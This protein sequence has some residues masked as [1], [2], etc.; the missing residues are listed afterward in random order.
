MT[1]IRIVLAALVLSAASCVAAWAEDAPVPPTRPLEGAPGAGTPRTAGDQPAQP[2]A[3][4]APIQGAAR[5]I[6]PEALAAP[7]PAIPPPPLLCC[8]IHLTPDQLDQI[9]AAMGK[10]PYADVATI[11]NTL[12]VQYQGQPHPATPQPG[13]K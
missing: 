3:P 8:I 1:P 11:I 13:A 10:L 6:S 4:V 2:S 9:A 5:G 7:Q 12:I